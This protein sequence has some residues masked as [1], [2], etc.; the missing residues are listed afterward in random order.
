MFFSAYRPERIIKTIVCVVMVSI[1]GTGAFLT[2]ARELNGKCEQLINKLRNIYIPVIEFD[3]ADIFSVIRL[4]N[5]LSRR[6]D[7]DN[8]GVAII[9]GFNK[10]NAQKLPEVTLSLGGR[11]LN[12]QDIIY[13]L[14]ESTGYNY[15]IEE[16]AVIISLSPVPQN[17]TKESAQ[18][19]AYYAASTE[20]KLKEIIINTIDFDDI[21]VETAVNF[22]QE[23]AR[24][25]GINIIFSHNVDKNEKKRVV[26]LFLRKRDLYQAI[27]FFCKAA[28]L[29]FRVVRNAVIISS[30]PFQEIKN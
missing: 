12:L 6:Y 27:Y 15:Y 30:P 7:P 11:G 1:L 18:R 14:C 26:N 17:E 22:F 29:N 19:R 9:A 16:N 20:R 8:A 10:K 3:N 5:R 21:T 28:N 23:S 25:H 13:L 24:E 4:L 2:E